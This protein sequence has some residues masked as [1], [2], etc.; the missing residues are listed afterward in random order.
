MTR[1]EKVN[2]I[3]SNPIQKDMFVITTR[4]IIAQQ[5]AAIKEVYPAEVVDEMLEEVNKIEVKLLESSLFEELIALVKENSSM[6]TDEEIDYLYMSFTHPAYIS[7]MEK[8]PVMNKIAIDFISA[9][10]MNMAKEIE[11]EDNDKI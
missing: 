10:T 5:E 6:Y 3:Y 4:Q 11:Q 7:V 9:F 1:E 2:A 8:V